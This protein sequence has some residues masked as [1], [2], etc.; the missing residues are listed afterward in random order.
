MKSVE[1]ANSGVR[2]EPCLSLDLPLPPP[3]LGGNGKFKSC[4]TRLQTQIF[5]RFSG[6]EGRVRLGVG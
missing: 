6:W 3:S 2:A 5:G 1:I 4:E